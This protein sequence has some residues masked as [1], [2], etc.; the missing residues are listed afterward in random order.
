MRPTALSPGTLVALS[1][2][3]IQVL[4]V[5]TQL[6]QFE[7]GHGSEWTMKKHESATRESIL[8]LLSDDEIASVSSAETA[9]RL[10]DGEEYLD[11]EQLDQGVRHAFG[12]ITPS[13]R[14]LQRKDVHEAT[15]N[16]ILTQLSA[17][18]ITRIPSRS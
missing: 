6:E 14:V 3:V 13:G 12:S 9:A 18:R 10:V 1:T 5:S 7:L 16:E 2:R 8:H 15:W 11:L 4:A 17:P